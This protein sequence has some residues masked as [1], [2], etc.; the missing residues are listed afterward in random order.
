MHVCSMLRCGWSRLAVRRRRSNSTAGKLAQ[1]DGWGALQR[2]TSITVCP[3]GRL[4]AGWFWVFGNWTATKTQHDP[5]SLYLRDRRQSASSGS[6]PDGRPATDTPTE[7]TGVAALGEH[8]PAG[9]PA[10]HTEHGKDR[11]LRCSN[12]DCCHQLATDSI[13]R[14]RTRHDDHL[15]DWII[16]IKFERFISSSS[17]CAQVSFPCTCAPYQD[18]RVDCKAALP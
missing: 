4:G 17:S 18:L 11:R 1:F 5:S 3:A 16:G 15:V 9:R 2:I 14:E 13:R 8:L 7:T 12:S 6:R 10:T